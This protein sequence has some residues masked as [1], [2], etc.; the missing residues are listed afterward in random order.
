MLNMIALNIQFWQALPGSESAMSGIRLWLGAGKHNG[1][2][3]GKN[4]GKNLGGALSAMLCTAAVAHHDPQHLRLQELRSTV[5][6]Q[7]AQ[8]L[9]ARQ[10]TPQPVSSATA[11]AAAQASQAGLQA[12]AD[13]NARHLSAQE[14]VEL[15][16]QLTRDLQAQRSTELGNR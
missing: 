4:W 9:P 2:N 16:R 3:L 13:A 11:Q 10:I 12:A 5:R 14:R 6:Q 15:R 1:K 8:P 7:M